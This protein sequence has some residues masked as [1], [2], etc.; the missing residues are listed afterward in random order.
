MD[1]T[2]LQKLLD[3]D[4]FEDWLSEVGLAP[5]EVTRIFSALDEGTG[6][7]L[8]SEF[9]AAITQMRGLPRAADVV[10]NL[11]ETRNIMLR[12]IR[13]EQRISPSSRQE[14]PISI[15]GIQ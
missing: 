6:G 7:V 10:I 4:E 9:E 8:F 2:E 3:T 12:L 5:Y 13:L 1:T 14:S 15:D 11:Y